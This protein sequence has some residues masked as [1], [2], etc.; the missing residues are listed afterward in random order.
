MNTPCVLIATSSFSCIQSPFIDLLE[1]NRVHVAYNPYKRRMTENELSKLLTHDV[2]GVVAGLEPYSNK[3]LANATQL[4]V[5]SRCG[6]ATDNVDINVLKGKNISLY[7]TPDAPSQ[8]VAELTV[9]LMLA[10]LRHISC[11]DKGIRSQQWKARMGSLLHG[12]TVGLLGYGRI[13]KKVAKLLNAFD[14][15]LLIHDPYTQSMHPSETMVDFETLMASSN[16]ISLHCPSNDGTRHIINEKSISM[17][18][19]GSYIVNTS[20]G[21]LIDEDALVPA[22]QA[23]HI[24]GAGL[25]VYAHEPYHGPLCELDQV[26]L[27]AHMGSY[28]KESRLMMEEEALSNLCYDLHKHSFLP[29]EVPM[30]V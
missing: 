29:Q 23:G 7:N 12:K 30:A 14:V 19:A 8:S 6:I 20:R 10:M 17:M 2:I 21:D 4:K 3:S 13:G 27:T 5:V 22:I 18:C 26:V 24:T 25:D 28:A 9:G 16:I 15:K 1:K 11:A